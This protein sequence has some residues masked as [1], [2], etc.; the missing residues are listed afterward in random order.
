MELAARTGAWKPS[1]A[2]LPYDAE[3]EWIGM[4]GAQFFATGVQVDDSN[5]LAME[6]DLLAASHLFGVGAITAGKWSTNSAQQITT[7]FKVLKTTARV[8]ISVAIIGR[9]SLTVDS[10][11]GVT[12]DGIHS[13]WNNDSDNTNTGELLVGKCYWN[14]AYFANMNLYSF[15]VSRGGVALG[16]FIP[17]RKD[18]I[19]F[20]YD[21]VSGQLFR[22]EGTGVFVIGP[23]V[24]SSR[25]GGC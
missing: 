3:V 4:R 19:G 6:Y 1:G 8:D 12:I 2:P 14:G 15:S 11:D 21:R 16:D 7:K 5:S 22:N 24:V 25:G 18:G 13:A 9:H 20:M 10:V 17:V 23:D